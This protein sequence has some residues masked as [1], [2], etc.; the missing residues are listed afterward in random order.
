MD[1]TLTATT[2]RTT[3]SRPSKR[4]RV[5]GQVPGTI[6]GLGRD[7]LT[8]SVE[9]RELRQALTTDAGLNAIITMKV[10]GTDELCIVRE[11]QRHAVRNDVIHVDFVR[12]DPKAEIL[13]DVPIVIE[14]EARKVLA[15]QGVVDQIHYVLPVWAKPD[16]IPNELF[17]DVSELE[18]NETLLV[19]DLTLPEGARTEMDPEEVIVTASVTRAEADEPVEGEDVEAGDEASAAADEEAAEAEES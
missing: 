14:G 1:V 13:V 5:D 19:S 16:A 3:G 15:E 2:G 7:P 6:Y 12:V 10:D 8:L 17:V 9:W 18:V 4:L 11:L